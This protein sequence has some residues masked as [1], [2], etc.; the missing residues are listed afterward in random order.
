MSENSTKEKQRPAEPMDPSTG[1]VIPAERQR[2]IERVLTYA[3]LRD[4]AA[5]NL[6]Q[7]AGGAGPEKPSEGAAERARMQADVARDIAQFLGEA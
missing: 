4:Q 2:C 7:A 5:V 6:D 1:R 3:K